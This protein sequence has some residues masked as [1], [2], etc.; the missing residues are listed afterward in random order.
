L[1]TK[2]NWMIRIAFVLPLILLVFAYPVTTVERED[3]RWLDPL[4]RTDVDTLPGITGSNVTAL[5]NRDIETLA[6]MLERTPERISTITHQELSVVE[7]WF[8]YATQSYVLLDNH[9]IVSLVPF[10]YLMLLFGIF[11]VVQ[12]GS[13]WQRHEVLGVF[14]RFIQSNP[15]RGFLTFL[16]ILIL[17]IPTILLMMWGMW[18]DA[19]VNLEHGV[20]QLEVLRMFV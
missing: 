12:E 4:D 11:F 6:D 14:A 2:I 15:I 13:H 16:G 3:A 9:F 5:T 17:L 20:K 10:I 8:A 19:L 1:G 18:I 7:G